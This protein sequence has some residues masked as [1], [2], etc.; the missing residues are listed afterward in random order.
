MKV[1]LCFYGQPRWI[2]NPYSWF[3][4]KYWIIDRYKAD[5][6]AHTMDNIKL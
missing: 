6:F 2:E 5:I 3:S 4:H 1:A